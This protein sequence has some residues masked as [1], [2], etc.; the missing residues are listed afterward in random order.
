[1]YFNIKQ[2]AQ[3]YGVSPATIWR[4]VGDGFF[5]KPHKLGPSTTRWHEDDL[6]AFE[7]QA[8]TRS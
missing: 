7:A 6:K 2:L 1:M 5:P 8:A 4:W 3:R